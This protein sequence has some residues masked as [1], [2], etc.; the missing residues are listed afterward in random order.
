MATAPKAPD[1][2]TVHNHY[3][4]Q[5]YQRRFFARPGQNKLWHLDLNPDV[6]KLPGG[7]TK[8]HNALHEYGPALC[9]QAEHLYTLHFGH[10]ATDVM[11]KDFF[12]KVDTHGETAVAFFENYGMRAG[13]HEAFAHMRNY[14][15]AQLFRT[16]KGL[17]YLRSFSKK[18]SHQNSLRAMQQVWPLYQTMWSEAVWEVVNCNTSATKFIVT[19]SPVSSYNKAVFP[20]SQEVLRHGMAALERLGTHTVFPLDCNHCLIITNLQYVRNP[21]VNPLKVRENPRY[22]EQA[23]FD[24][25]KVQRGREIGEAEVVAINYVLKKGA[26]RY[27]AAGEKDWLYPERKMASTF[28]PKLGGSHFLHPDPRR[29]SFSTEIIVGY[30]DGSTYG[31]NEYGHHSFDNKRAKALRDVEWET[32]E[33]AKRAWD[34]RDRRAGR[35][36]PPFD[37]DYF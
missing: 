31:Q 37:Q 22:F 33:A 2:F 20:G 1:N 35:G 19:D 26:R 25:R 34:E 21:K 6:I 23:M 10:Y 18:P 17:E 30:K 16:P 32:F 27:I 9:F 15:S 28:W 24:L 29:V 3:V 8:L 11:E 12:G 13:V 36:P 4:P 14:L 7:R 5:W